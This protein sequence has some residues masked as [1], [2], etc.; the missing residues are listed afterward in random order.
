MM[1]I[2]DLNTRNDL[3]RSL[4]GKICNEKI[5]GCEITL[6]KGTSKR[7]KGIKQWGLVTCLEG[8][9]WITQEHDLRDYILGPGDV[10]FITLPGNVVMQAL[11]NSRIEILKS[12][13]CT[14]YTGR[15]PVFH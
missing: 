4:G 12:L 11:R 6:E 13:K 8:E 9:V 2:T 10:F 14:S 7:L 1:A 15:R 3:S 5:P